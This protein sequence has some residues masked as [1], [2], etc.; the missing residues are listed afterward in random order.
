MR[1]RETPTPSEPASNA[2][3]S[4][5]ADIFTINQHDPGADLH[6]GDTLALTV[7]RSSAVLVVLDK[8]AMPLSRLWCLYGAFSA[9]RRV[10]PTL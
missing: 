3:P 2:C 6:G 4:L 10:Q 9:A 8:N 5:R 1:S 7:K